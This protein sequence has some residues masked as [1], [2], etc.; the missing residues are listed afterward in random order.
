MAA[1]RLRVVFV[2][3]SKYAAGGAVERFRR[4]FMPNATLCHMA[5]LTPATVRGAAVEVHAI[6]E[7]VQTD[8]DYL[9]LLEDDADAG[10]TLLVLVGVQS[11]QLHRALDLAA[12]A[13]RQG[14]RHVVIG[15]PHV[16]TCDTT[17]LQGRGVS[18]AL[19]EAELVWEAILDDAVTGELQ[20]VYGEGQRWRA[21]LDSPVLSPPSARE[22]KRHVIPML[23]IYPARGCPYRCNFC[24]VIKIAGQ[25]VRSEPVAT[26]IASMKAAKA[27]GVKMV[28]FT[29]DNFNKYDDAPALLQTMIDE[30]IALPFFAQCDTQVV[31]QEGLVELM[32]R[33]GCWQIFVGVESLD[34]TTLLRAKKAQNHPDTYKDLI[35]VCD[36][37]DITVH[38]SNIL[39]FPD[40]TASSV[41]THLAAIK[42]LSPLAASFY[43]LT[44]IPGTEQYDDFRREGLITEMNLDRYDATELCWRHPHLSAKQLKG[45]MLKAF[46]EYYSPLSSFPRIDSWRRRGRRVPPFGAPFFALQAIF[47]W[48]SALR[49]QHPM[50]GGLGHVVRDRAADYQALRRATYDV[51]LVPLPDSLPNPTAAEAMG[52]VVRPTAA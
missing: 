16:M 14:V 29:S 18:F 34:R 2:K 50:S 47:Q 7:Y 15:G 36:R 24:S 49:G 9:G 35:R 1:R 45:H 44:P 17:S 37:H 23:G 13:R 48:M 40:D 3:P 33:A 20:P 26:T 19:C 6:D 46:R 8:L 4:G 11:H 30:K 42:A 41:E 38:F 25:K 52:R 22:L 27:A 43:V 31:K 5:S 12:L 51:D 32:H 10:E 28:M 39:G 21:A